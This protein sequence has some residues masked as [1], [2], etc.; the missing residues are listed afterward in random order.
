MYESILGPV[1]KQHEGTIDGALDAV[2][3]VLLDKMK[4][5]FDYFVD[6]LKESLNNTRMKGANDNRGE[7]KST[8][9]FEFQSFIGGTTGA[10]EESE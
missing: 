7:S 10:D 5:V 8:D 1:L 3:K 2:K 6:C 9:H 4:F